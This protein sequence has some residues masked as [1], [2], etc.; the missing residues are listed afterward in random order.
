[1]PGARQ[2]IQSISSVTGCESMYRLASASI[3]GE[4]ARTFA[5]N[6]RLGLRIATAPHPMT[7]AAHRTRDGRRWFTL[8]NVQ[9]AK[10]PTT[11][12]MPDTR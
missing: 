6:A 7:S 2:P 1:M 8:S 11:R 3:D 4:N 10:A 9:S 12:I 5:S